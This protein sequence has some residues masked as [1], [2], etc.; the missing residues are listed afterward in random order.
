MGVCRGRFRDT[1]RKQRLFFLS[2]GSALTKRLP[3][4]LE[5]LAPVTAR[6]RPMGEKRRM[7]KYAWCVGDRVETG[8]AHMRANLCVACMLTH[9]YDNFTNK[10]L[11]PLQAKIYISPL[12]EEW[13][14]AAICDAFVAL[15]CS[16]QTFAGKQYGRCE[17]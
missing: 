11:S 16:Y 4:E 8:A 17:K 13:W 15:S 1:V 10:S 2:F 9:S 7:R 14:L 3:R 12:G 6:C 5:T